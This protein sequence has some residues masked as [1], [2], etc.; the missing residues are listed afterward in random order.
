MLAAY[1]RKGQFPM[2]V[3]LLLTALSVAALIGAAAPASAAPCRDAK[4]K[5]TTCPKP[6]PTKCRDAKGKF[7]PCPT[8]TATP[9]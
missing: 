9:G 3:R 5:F 7:T 2:R 1:R 6:K 8:P 4:G